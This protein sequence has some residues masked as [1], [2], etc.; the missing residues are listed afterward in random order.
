MEKKSVTKKVVKLSPDGSCITTYTDAKFR[1]HD[2]ITAAMAEDRR[3]YTA[4]M[5]RLQSIE[6]ASGEYV[7]SIL[8]ANGTI[9]MVSYTF[10]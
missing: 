1:S 6:E 3:S 2:D 4:Y 7:L 9:T 10:Q 5:D 8:Q